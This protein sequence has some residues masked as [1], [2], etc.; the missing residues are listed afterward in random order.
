[1]CLSVSEC[2]Q[3]LC[4][5]W[6]DMTVLAHRATTVVILFP[7]PVTQW[8]KVPALRAG[9]KPSFLERQQIPGQEFNHSV[10]LCNLQRLSPDHNAFLI[11]I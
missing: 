1:M 2:M 10:G 3:S 5:S 8:F 6:E 11:R 7:G 4:H 9:T